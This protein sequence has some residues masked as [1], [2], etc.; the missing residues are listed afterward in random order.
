MN[1][2]WKCHQCGSVWAPWFPGPCPHPVVASA[3]RN[4]VHNYAGFEGQDEATCVVC[5]RTEFHHH[6]KENE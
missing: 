6:M 4:H 2:S 1:V 5:G 3:P